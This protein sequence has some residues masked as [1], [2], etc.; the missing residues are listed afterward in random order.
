[1]TPKTWFLDFDGTLVS[2]KSHMSDNDY[3]LPTTKD[4]F[5]N[6]S[7]ED[8]VV[9]TTARKSEEHYERIVSF[10]GLHK[11]K[12]YKIVCD[13]PAGKRILINDKKPDGTLTAYCYNLER[14]KGI[15]LEEIKELDDPTR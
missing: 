4:F 11:I 6:I 2:Q 14:D 12:N 15:N 3:I 7:C 5:E 13:L 8:F 9:I 10:L 1:M